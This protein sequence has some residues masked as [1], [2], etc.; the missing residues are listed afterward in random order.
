MDKD[1]AIRLL[2]GSVAEAARAIGV[3]HQAVWQWPD[4]LPER[5]ADRVQAA[6]WRMEQERKAV[7][8]PSRAAA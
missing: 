8:E 5:I 6:L 3:T 2:G 7:A 1:E 4:P